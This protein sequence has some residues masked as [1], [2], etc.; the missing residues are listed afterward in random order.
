MIAVGVVG[1]VELLVRIAVAAVL[2]ACS[3]GGVRVV[4]LNAM[5][6]ES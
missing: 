3:V 2:D 5:V 4:I 6:Y 1:A